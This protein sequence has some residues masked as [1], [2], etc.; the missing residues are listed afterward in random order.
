MCF[1]F[2]LTE[3][4]W[5]IL[6]LSFIKMSC[7]CSLLFFLTFVVFVG[8]RKLMGV[9]KNSPTST[10]YLGPLANKCRTTSRQNIYPLMRE[11]QVQL[12]LN[13]GNN[14]RVV[15]KLA[16]LEENNITLRD[17][18]ELL[19]LEHSIIGIAISLCCW[20]WSK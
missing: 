14:E 9:V 10:E 13:N 11:S 7:G 16:N 12:L 18:K 20:S 1:R 4:S 3:T 2:L 6:G 19:S 8:L 5:F 15:W 17:L